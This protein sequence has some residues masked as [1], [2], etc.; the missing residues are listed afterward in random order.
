ME[1]QKYE[2]LPKFLYCIMVVAGL[3]LLFL[4]LFTLFY[5]RPGAV[6]DLPLTRGW[7]LA[8][9]F[10]KLTAGLAYGYL[11]GAL[12]A[13][14]G[15]CWS[16]Y[17]TSVEMDNAV[18]A[19]KDFLFYGFPHR[20]DFLHYA[21]W[22]DLKENL[23]IDLLSGMNLLTA[24]SF[25]VDTLLLCG[26]TFGGWLKLVRLLST[27]FRGYPKWAYVLPFLF[28]SF[29]FFYTGLHPD[30]ILF[31][32]L[33]YIAFDVYRLLQGEKGFIYFR[34]S[35]CLCLLVLLKIFLL[36]FLV[37][38]LAGWILYRRGFRARLAWVVIGLGTVCIFAA[39]AP[40]IA[41]RQRLYLERPSHSAIGVINLA[42]TP[43]S[44]LTHFPY[45]VWNGLISPLPT[46]GSILPFL[47][48]GGEMLLLWILAALSCFRRSGRRLSF[49]EKG[50]LW[51][52]FVNYLL[53]GYTVTIMWDVYRYRGLFL[54]FVVALLLLP[55]LRPKTVL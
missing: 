46:T 54:P 36:L 49:Y 31:A 21:F 47:L 17:V 27:L 9:F 37:P 53:I 24:R 51:L 44:L 13:E 22:N 2:E 42:P 41:S 39:A 16:Y 4:S 6:R 11:V 33:G 52:A 18:H 7:I 34:L 12:W 35:V 3:F 26:F 38:V 15:D 43:S 20:T 28:P 40:E 8:L 1:P 45:A 5:L 19:V 30:S 50:W 25:Y 32:L 10:I 14:G 55:L 48:A 29:L 23:F